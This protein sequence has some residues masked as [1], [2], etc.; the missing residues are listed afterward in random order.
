[1]EQPPLIARRVRLSMPLQNKIGTNKQKERR[2][3]HIMELLKNSNR[4]LIIQQ[5]KQ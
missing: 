3:E 4:S 2:I 1:V 5:M